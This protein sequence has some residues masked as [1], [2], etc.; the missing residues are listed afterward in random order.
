MADYTLALEGSTYAGS[1]ALICDREVIAERT[2]EDTGIP[3]R[4]GRDERVLPSVAECLETANVS[5]KELT[6]IV[7]G[8]GPGSFTSLR[9]SASVAKG[10]AVGTGRP[11][12]AASS[13]LLS[14][15][16]SAELR[17]GVYLSVLPAMRGEFFA[18]QIEIL[19]S[20]EMRAAETVIIAEADLAVAAHKLDAQIV[21]PGRDIDSMPRARGVSR[22]LDQIISIGPVDIDTWEPAYGRLAEAQVKW[23]ATHGRP[24]GAGA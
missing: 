22:L 1:V 21:G 9:V 20:G 11:L 6:R 14:V 13:L 3:S 4:G 10:I 17:P 8:A 2:L 5:P 18:S 12:Y 16:A 15:S 24:L 19:D 23:E 7:C